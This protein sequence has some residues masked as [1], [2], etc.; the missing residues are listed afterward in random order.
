MAEK[1]QSTILSKLKLHC[2]GG[3]CCN[4][5]YLAIAEGVQF[6]GRKVGTRQQ[7]FP[8]VVSAVTETR[9]KSCAFFSKVSHLLSDKR[10][11]FVVVFSHS[12]TSRLPHFHQLVTCTRQLFFARSSKL[13]N[14]PVCSIH[15]LLSLSLSP[16][17]GAI[18]TNKIT[19]QPDGTTKGST[20]RHLNVQYSSG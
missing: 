20:G 12:S 13:Y 10:K 18:R 9:R 14:Y 15:K 17:F 8:E 6:G 5:H 2:A 7:V 4:G 3:R 11:Y 16:L 19:C 1:K